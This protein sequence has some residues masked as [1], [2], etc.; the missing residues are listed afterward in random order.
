MLM[1][2][3]G[4]IGPSYQSQSVSVDNQSCV[5]WY[6][7]VNPLGTG[8]EREVACL[9]PTPG[10]T[11]LAQLG[12]SPIRALY[13]SQ[14]GI[15]FAVAGNKFYSIDSSWV[16]TERGSLNTTSGPVSMS[17]NG[18]YVVFVDGSEGF[19]WNMDTNTY[20]QITDVDF[21]P[22]DRVTYQDGYFIFNR[23]GTSQ[24]FIS[25]LNSVS[26]DALDITDAEARADNTVAVISAHKNIFAFGK[27][28]I[29]VYFN[30]G[31]A[32]FPFDLIPG[33]VQDIGCLSS[34]SVVKIDNDI[35][36]LG[37]S[38]LGN[39]IIYRM[40]GYQPVRVS[41]PSIEG[42][43]RELTEDQRSAATA[44]A[45]QQGGH[46]FYCLN[47]P[48]LES[49]WCFDL[50]N[51]F[52]HERTYLDAFGP[53]R[54]RA[55]VHS[56]AYGKN[57]VGD[58]ESGN[59]YS[60]DLGVYTDNGTSMRRVRRCTH[61]SKNQQRIVHSFLHVD[62]Q[63]GVGLDGSGQGTD[64]Q[65]MMRFSDDDGQTWSNERSSSI[66]KIGK[67]L[68]RAVFRRLGVAVNRVY[69]VAVTDPVNAVL[70]GAGIDVKEGRH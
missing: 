59:I 6:L 52:W 28:T 69:E 70:I 60:L 26:F 43:I 41:T 44:W 22:A 9:L 8:K 11:L 19:S 23:K 51:G 67:T 1:R 68:T 35:L 13:T 47:I 49:T 14:T 25:E 31:N 18:T 53:Q 12:G 30:S 5:N 55:E 50:S 2:Y 4:F 24:W 46:I 48:G 42:L 33:S 65:L 3:P 32:D 21:Y 56:L 38:D 64:P 58:W 61:F 16:A 54:H 29:E 10:L 37:G 17:D 39:G 34:A 7:E 40:Q 27:Q 62:M 57:V 20:A 45:Y 66:G 15:L 36:F 63:P